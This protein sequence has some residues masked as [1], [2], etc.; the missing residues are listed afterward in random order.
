MTMQEQDRERMYAAELA[1]LTYREDAQAVADIQAAEEDPGVL[2]RIGTAAAAGAA[3][4]ADESLTFLAHDL[5]QLMGFEGAGEL[6]PVAATLGLDDYQPETWY[7]N[8]TFDI[9]NLG[10]AWAVPGG[11]AMKGGQ[12]AVKAGK[13]L[14][15]AKAAGKAEDAAGAAQGASKATPKGRQTPEE[16]Q[17]DADNLEELIKEYELDDEMRDQ[18]PGL[19]KEL[20]ALK[21]QQKTALREGTEA[22]AEEAPGAVAQKASAVLDR[23]KGVLTGDTAKMMA[24]EAARGAAGGL[25]G[26]DPFAQRMLL[27]KQSSP[28]L[29]DIISE[30]EEAPDPEHSRWQGR[31]AN[32]M[33]EAGLAAAGSVIVKKT[34][35]W[36]KR[37]IL[38]R[39]A[40]QAEMAPGV[41]ETAAGA[42]AEKA[43]QKEAVQGAMNAERELA[44]VTAGAE[45][46]MVPG[47]FGADVKAQ[48]AAQAEG[49]A[50]GFTPEA[51]AKEAEAAK[52]AK[53]A[54]TELPAPRPPAAT[55]GE[56]VAA[57]DDPDTLVQTI[58]GET[59]RATKPD[60]ALRNSMMRV[61]EVAQKAGVG[62]A[63]QKE[64]QAFHQRMLEWRAL[65][66]AAGT[67]APNDALRGGAA[68]AAARKYVTA[69]KGAL[70]GVEVE[71][72]PLGEFTD[73]DA[74]WKQTVAKN[75]LYEAHMPSMARERFAS[76]RSRSAAE[77]RAESTLGKSVGANGEV[78]PAGKLSKADWGVFRQNVGMHDGIIVDEAYQP[79]SAWSKEWM[80]RPIDVYFADVKSVKDFDALTEAVRGQTG[81]AQRAGGE[82]GAARSLDALL[83]DGVNGRPQDMVDQLMGKRL[84]TE[85][86]KGQQAD[87]LDT[88]VAMSSTVRDLA[89]IAAGKGSTPQ[90]RVE[91]IRAAQKLDAYLHWARGDTELAEKA[92]RA[93]QDTVI[94]NLDEVALRMR[95]SDILKQEGDTYARALAGSIGSRDTLHGVTD[96]VTRWR[97]DQRSLMDKARIAG[98]RYVSRP[99]R[100][101]WINSILSSPATHGRNIIGNSILPMMQIPEHFIAGTLEGGFKQG[102]REAMGAM[103]G[104]FAGMKDGIRM[105]GL[106]WKMQMAE[107][108]GDT[109]GIDRIAQ[110]IRGMDLELQHRE[111][112][113]KIKVDD[114]TNAKA[115][116]VPQVMLE[117]M[118]SNPGWLKPLSSFDVGVRRTLNAPTAALRS[119]DVFYKTMT[120]RMEVNRL[121]ARQAH[122]EGLNGDAFTTR[123]Q[124]LIKET[125]TEGDIGTQAMKQSHINTF[126]NDLE[127][128]AQT[129]LDTLNRIPTARY[130][131]PFF[132]TPWNITVRSLEHVPGVGRY[133]GRQKALWAEGGRGKQ[134]VIARQVMGGAI[135]L[136][137]TPMALNGNLIG[138]DVHNPELSWTSRKLGRQPYSVKIGDTWFDYRRTGGSLGIS[139]GMVTDAITAVHAAST[140]EELEVATALWHTATGIAGSLLG[141]TWAGDVHDF[142]DMVASQNPKAAERFLTRTGAG[143]MPLSGLAD[144]VRESI[145]LALGLGRY[146]DISGRGG[147]AGA[148]EPTGEMVS[149]AWTAI[150]RKAI[151]PFALIG[152]E[153]RKYPKR[154]LYGAPIT[155]MQDGPFSGALA[156]TTVYSPFVYMQERTDPLSKEILR[157][158]PPGIAKVPETFS[159][160]GAR[161]DVRR[162]EY[163]REQYDFFS[164]RRGELLLQHGTRRVGTVDY[165]NASDVKRTALLLEAGD[166]ATRKAMQETVDKFA[167]I[168]KRRTAAQTQM[169]NAFRGRGH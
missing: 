62:S 126:T 57:L 164:K 149:E 80:D 78:L 83:R 121:A 30:W 162:L 69:V 74:L 40:G 39:K 128:F 49:T 44:A 26:R 42:A 22:V 16:L 124:Q 122:K 111:F 68:V 46:Q 152:E 13:A 66:K 1:W 115:L 143:F 104:L 31:L 133:I 98:K 43:A 165:R 116:G 118:K 81:L 86:Y 99:A 100:E 92:M 110:S 10:T 144:D 18:V 101:L 76:R 55:V 106:D 21:A 155:P 14:T 24:R 85:L 153:G 117:R 47:D 148:Q 87:I 6:N 120:Y 151:G 89:K 12:M 131:V 48:Q 11:A 103:Q 90:Q 113:Q 27:L 119:E 73:V 166:F 33:E 28:E 71:D 158:M 169:E 51:A 135:G 94:E 96:L 132:R 140:D 146:Q 77:V 23:G 8:A 123:V 3:E 50:A 95:R 79:G 142:M 107:M 64:L 147:L 45:K 102:G 167:D 63:G 136:A 53:E 61:H 36:V 37:G 67:T 4:T 2:E 108:A 141:D 34:F 9:V 160:S 35:D 59:M 114:L 75:P 56:V 97:A 19:Q 20:A 157:L 145:S 29:N 72:V 130:V 60:A 52:A 91:F 125:T 109:A 88:V 156:G 7:E 65:A 5:P 105:M 150:Y 70:K 129:T 112:I 84:R 134:E 15:G 54:G 58:V 17:K 137:L 32:A 161:G 38:A 93:T 41:K 154:G 82:A 25:I 138:G 139:V 127:G 168:R 159:V 163:T